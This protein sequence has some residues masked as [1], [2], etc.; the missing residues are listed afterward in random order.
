MA[1]GTEGV[2][3][4]SVGHG[5]ENVLTRVSPAK[6]QHQHSEKARVALSHAESPQT[7]CISYEVLPQRF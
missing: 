6:Q 5:H 3:G 1:A 2:G 7:L 4:V